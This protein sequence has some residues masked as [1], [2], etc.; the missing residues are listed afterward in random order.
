MPVPFSL[1]ESVKVT[2]CYQGAANAVSCDYIDMDDYLKGYFLITHTGSADTDLTLT[3]YESDDVA[4][5]T[6]AAVTTTCN[7]WADTN[8]G[9]S[10]DTQVAQTA[11]Y[12]YTIDTGNYPAQMI[13]WEIDP[14]IL[15]DGY[16][17]VFLAD[18]G[19]NASNTISILFVG[20]PRYPQATLPTTIA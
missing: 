10:S 12:A 9:T 18:S 16:P 2:L 13:M 20:I 7:I 19:G 15:S 1:A 8:V 11:A 14:A 17:V 5:S 6:T 3:L 4:G